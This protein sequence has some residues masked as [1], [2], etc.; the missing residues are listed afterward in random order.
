MSN[1]KTDPTPVITCLKLSKDDDGSIVDP[2][3]FKM[4]VCSLIYLTMTRTDIMYAVIMISRFMES[5]KFSHWKACKII[6]TYVSGTKNL[7][8]MYSTL[9]IFNLVGYIDSD[10]GGNENDRKSTYG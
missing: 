1:C 10:N 3:L 9:E 6:L 8:I 7:G 4:S 2:T 5:P